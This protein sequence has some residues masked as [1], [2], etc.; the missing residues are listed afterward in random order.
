MKLRRVSMRMLKQF[1]NQ[2][3][4]SVLPE[5]R[6][7]LIS[8]FYPQNEKSYGHLLHYE[9]RN[10]HIDEVR[11]RLVG[12]NKIAAKF[13]MNVSTS[14]SVITRKSNSL[15]QF[16]ENHM[17][18]KSF[19]E[20]LGMK[21]LSVANTW[22]IQ[23]AVHLSSWLL[24]HPNKLEDSIDK[25]RAVQKSCE[26]NV[27]SHLII[28]SIWFWRKTY[29]NRHLC[30]KVLH[31]KESVGLAQ[32]VQPWVTDETVK[33]TVSFL[34]NCIHIAYKSKSISHTESEKLT[35][36]KTH[37]KPHGSYVKMVR[38]L[39][40]LIVSEWNLVYLSGDFATFCEVMII[41]S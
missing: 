12:D 28:D 17:K 31:D 32:Y 25:V 8:C 9:V 3:K 10:G 22:Q 33:W 23:T 40:I 36:N 5:N 21:R 16:N 19:C 11:T 34:L 6:I 18:L 4:Q 1:L 20:N 2:T 13:T 27:N 26:H 41:Q 38:S 14:Y 37:K 39:Q 30:L 7:H 35:H 29:S 15:S 24:L